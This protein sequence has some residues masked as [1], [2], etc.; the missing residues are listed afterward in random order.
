MPPRVMLGG[1]NAHGRNVDERNTLADEGLRALQRQIDALHE[2]LR[3]G[4][5]LR[6]GESKDKEEVEDTYEEE[7]EEAID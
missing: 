6:R 2:E 7:V 1:K 5:N 3:R 4:F